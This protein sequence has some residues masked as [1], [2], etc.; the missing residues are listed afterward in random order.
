MKILAYEK[1]GALT[2]DEW[3]SDRAVV[4]EVPKGYR[5]RLGL[6]GKTMIVGPE[7]GEEFDIDEAIGRGIARRVAG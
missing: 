2:F 5:C 4:L 1:D 7:P 6:F 3:Q